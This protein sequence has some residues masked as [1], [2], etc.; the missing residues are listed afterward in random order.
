MTQKKPPPIEA[1]NEPLT[2]IIELMFF[3]YRD[4]VAD[5]DVLLMKKNLGRAH[6]RALHFIGRYPCLSVTELLEILCIT[7]QSLSRVLKE[8]LGDG[9]VIQTIS[10]DDRRKRLLSLSKKGDAFLA[11]LIAP[12]HRRF[13]KAIK[14]TDS[15][16]LA[17]WQAF[18][19][20]LLNTHTR[21]ISSEYFAND[22]KNHDQ[23]G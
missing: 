17:I 20:K 7:K 3:A 22:E 23:A 11:E 19:I 8:L 10:Q 6:H 18:M 12:Q 5:P 21:S 14:E 13:K 15:E 2:E 1:T 9:Y 16:T 4:F